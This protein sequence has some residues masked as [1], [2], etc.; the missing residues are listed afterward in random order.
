M[1]T[2]ECLSEIRNMKNLKV[3]TVV[4]TRPQFIKAAPVLRAIEQHNLN[5]PD[6]KILEVL[7]HTGQ[8]YDSNMSKVFFE[9]LK[10]KEPDYNLEVGSGTHAYQTGEMLK[11]VEKV[12]QKEKPELVMV[13]GDTNSTLAGALAASKVHIPVA[14]IEAGLRSFNKQMPEEINRVLTDHISDLLFCPSK[15]AVKNLEREG[16]KDGVHQVGDVMYDSLLCNTRI[17]EERSKILGKLRLSSKK[18]A[19]ATV[20]RQ[21]N[22]D[23]NNRL[24]SIFKGLGKIAK[25]GIKVLVPLHPRTQK[26]VKSLNISLKNLKII[27]PVS[28]LD[29]ILL[30]KNSKVILTDSGGVQ[31]E[32]YWFKVPCITLREE[33][34]WVETVEV[35]WNTLVATN[36]DK[37]F[38]AFKKVLYGNRPENFQNSCY[39]EGNA[40]KKILEC[41]R[42]FNV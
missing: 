16:I 14:H 40:A 27:E 38:D 37:I 23:N 20:H 11:R 12:L 21:E 3:V 13:Y 17:A 7:V 22:T 8:H 9:E 1:A 4:G 41:I 36:A 34:E 10:L 26:R 5:H 18:Y 29:M 32:A 33:T 42:K 15:K 24:S 6:R 25:E 28:Y 30:E 39:G 19:L 35:G 31:K 2:N